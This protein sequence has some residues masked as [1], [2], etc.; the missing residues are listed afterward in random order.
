MNDEE[1]REIVPVTLG[2]MIIAF[3][4]VY[5]HCGSDKD[6]ILWQCVFMFCNCNNMNTYAYL[7]SVRA[8]EHRTGGT[9][10][11]FLCVWIIFWWICY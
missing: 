7:S 4:T 5:W 11:L 1:I 10:F 9:L 2:A 3:N 6:T 8:S